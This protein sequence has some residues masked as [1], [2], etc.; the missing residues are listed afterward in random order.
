M[1]IAWKVADTGK[2]QAD[3]GYALCYLFIYLSSFANFHASWK[4]ET[5]LIWMNK[6]IGSTCFYVI[7]FV[8]ARFELNSITANPLGLER[9]I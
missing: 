1:L 8:V 2:K 7:F 4:Y 6:G 3:L 9:I 5:L